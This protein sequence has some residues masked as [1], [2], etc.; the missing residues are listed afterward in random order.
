MQEEE[1][2]LREIVLV[3][4]PGVVFVDFLC[5][6]VIKCDG[7]SELCQQVNN[8]S[9]LHAGWPEEW[10]GYGKVDKKCS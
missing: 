9:V 5:S 3:H 7:Q 6:C 2:I 4:L 10:M 8:Y 1:N